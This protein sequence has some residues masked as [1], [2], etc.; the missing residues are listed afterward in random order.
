MGHTLK[1]PSGEAY[2]SAVHVQPLGCTTSDPAVSGCPKPTPEV[3]HE[4]STVDT[5]TAEPCSGAVFSPVLCS[6]CSAVS[7]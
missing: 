3:A 1:G 6:R 4:R 5:A 2:G 7:L